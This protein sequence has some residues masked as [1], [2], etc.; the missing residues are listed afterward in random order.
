MARVTET[1]NPLTTDLD[2]SSPI[3]I[4][5]LLRQSDAQLFAGFGGW[6]GVLDDRTLQCMELVRRALVQRPRAACPLNPFRPL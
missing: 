6:D 3:E 5:R 1:P 2:V 4:V